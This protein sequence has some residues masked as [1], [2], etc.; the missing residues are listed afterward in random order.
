MLL[1]VSFRC[2]FQGPLGIKL[3]VCKLKKKPQT[4]DTKPV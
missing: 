4:T 1:G 3:G 2:R